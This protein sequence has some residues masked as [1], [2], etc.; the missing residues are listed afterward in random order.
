M[1]YLIQNIQC[2]LSNGLTL[3]PNITITEEEH[4]FRSIEDLEKYRHKLRNDLNK[5]LRVVNDT[6]RVKN[7]YFTYKELKDAKAE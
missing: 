2:E 5:S 3:P 1:K 7:I 4:S 6:W